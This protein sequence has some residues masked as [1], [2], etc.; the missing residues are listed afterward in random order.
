MKA[1]ILWTILYFGV[2]C[3][4]TRISMNY[5]NLAFYFANILQ[6]CGFSAVALFFYGL[7]IKDTEK[8]KI[9]LLNKIFL[10]FLLGTSSIICGISLYIFV[11]TIIQNN[12]ILDFTFLSILFA[13]FIFAVVIY[14]NSK[15]FKFK[16]RNK[17]ELWIQLM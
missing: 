5:E 17:V 4:I 1:Q 11:M 16:F 14:Q 3:I 2:I 13:I 6:F 8:S 12:T 15:N 10:W 7:A 9:K